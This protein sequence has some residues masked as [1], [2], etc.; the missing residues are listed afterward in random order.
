[1]YIH[2]ACCS[3]DGL[4]DSFKKS[5]CSSLGPISQHVFKH[6]KNVNTIISVVIPTFNRQSLTSQAVDSVKCIQPELIEVVVVDDCGEQPYEY[7]N[8]VNANGIRVRVIRAKS[9]GGPG[10][11]RSLGVTQAKGKVIAF[12]DSD[13]IYG[14]K[15]IDTVLL[16]YSA[17][18]NNPLATIFIVG[19]AEGASLIVDTVESMLRI[20]PE[21]WHLIFVR[22]IFM[23]SNSFHTPSIVLS[24]SACLFSESLRYCED[25]YTNSMGI[26]GV[27]RFKKLEINAC[28]LSRRQGTAGGESEAKWR[29]FKGE[30][31][32]R[33]ELLNANSIPLIYKVLVPFG[34]LYQVVRSIVMFVL[35]ILPAMV[36]SKTDNKHKT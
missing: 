32:V 17:S 31:R 34:M 8:P 21:K 13:D 25:Y 10:V 27:E 18:N 2:R 7:Q 12:L 30:M 16:E 20:I 36:F 11:A 33:W 15:W 3:Y 22:V 5:K 9:N 23:F 24:K 6:G 28:L 14:S 1:M 4:S 35:R 26:F 19:S 29:M